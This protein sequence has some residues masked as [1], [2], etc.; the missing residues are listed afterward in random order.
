MEYF[1]EFL[2]N[3]LTELT[4]SRHQLV[5]LFGYKNRNKSFRVIDAWLNGSKLPNTMQTKQ[6]ASVLQ[7]SHDQLQQRIDQQ[8]EQIKK[9]QQNAIYEKW[10]AAKNAFRPHFAVYQ[11]ETVHHLPLP[12]FTTTNVLKKTIELED[13]LLT[14]SGDDLLQ[15]CKNIIEGYLKDNPDRQLSEKEFFKFHLEFE[16]NSRLC[17]DGKGNAI[18]EPEEDSEFFDLDEKLPKSDG[19]S[20]WNIKY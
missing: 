17:F 15:A 4:I 8:I 20:I 9:D 12:Y 11:S 14:S 13:D 5:T 10:L 6:L 19:K 1:N 7:I 16:K 18:D 2:L 3:R